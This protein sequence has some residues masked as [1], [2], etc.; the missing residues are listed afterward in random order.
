MCQV[1][2]NLQALGDDVVGLYALDV[3]HEANAAGVVFV[4]RVVETLLN[5]E[6]DHARV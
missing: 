2:E 3:D 6:S 5:W 1:D 4:S